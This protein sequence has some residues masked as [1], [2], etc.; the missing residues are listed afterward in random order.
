[1]MEPTA[2]QFALI[3]AGQ[4]GL[5]HA[6]TLNQLVG[7][8]FAYVCDL[9]KTRAALV[10]QISD[11]IEFITEA[12]PILTDESVQAVIIAT[13]AET[14]YAIA[15][16]CLEAGKHVLVE[17][18]LALFSEQAKELDQLA[19]AQQKILMAGHV[20]LYHPAVQKLKQ[21]ID[22]GQLGKLQYIYSNRLNLGTVRK[23]ENILWSF[24]PHDI[25]ILQY[26]IGEYPVEVNA[27]G[28][29]FLQ[30]GI[31]DVTLTTLTYP[32][33]IHA[34]IH[35]SWLHPFKEQR[36][37]AI[38]DRSMAVLEDSRKEDKLILYPKGIDWINGEPQKR[39]GEYQ[40]IDHD[41]KLPLT[42]QLEHFIDCIE[43]NK[44][45]I[46]DGKS[47]ITVL[48]ILEQAQHRLEEKPAPDLDIPKPESKPDYF[49]HPLAVV[50]EGCEIGTGTKIWHF[51][52]VQSGAKIG[53]KCVL[54][55]NVN[56]GNNVT[57]GNYVKIQ[58]NVS[59]Y[60]GVELED[61]VFCGPSMVF[62]NVIDPRCEFPQSGSA[63]Y[64]QTVVKYG[65]SIGA[66]ATIVCGNTLGRFSFIAAGAVVTKDVP[67]Y[68]LMAGVPARRVGWMS[69]H[70][71]RL[72]EP[73][74]H[75][76]MICP[77][78]GWRYQE[79]APELLRCLDHPE[80]QP[81]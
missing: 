17:K 53:E 5:N 2:I 52:H 30:P 12:Q 77:K 7:D 27:K 15:K 51:S 79:V 41:S 21:M 25:S 38:G 60:E 78:S 61:Y 24:A 80:D 44:T 42:A 69:R 23:E 32:N 75:G 64:R 29:V 37:V 22:Q 70:G 43:H 26:L 6:R 14:H 71:A 58:N 19:T 66:N 45:P 76:I 74:P 62:T 10:H 47:A 81:I 57:I 16:T 65:A 13:P 55:Q 18:P 67:D 11:S 48:E 54:G 56:V 36:L 73:D 59:V 35:V 28:A 50:D 4:W 40:V 63:F 3:G 72:P 31:H 34:H 9:D 49:V 1:M 46:T 68:A 39:E 33:N 20:L 8:R